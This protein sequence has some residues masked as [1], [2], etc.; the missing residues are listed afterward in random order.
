MVLSPLL[1][2]SLICLLALAFTSSTNAQTRIQIRGSDT[3]LHLNEQWAKRF[4]EQQKSL[5]IEVSGGGSG[6]GL[7]SLI[8]G[9]V[10]L[11]AASRELKPEEVA[12]LTTADQRP[13]IRVEVALDAVAVYV[14]ESNQV[15]W[16]SIDQLR[17]IY[18]GSI[19]NWSE[20]GGRNTAIH[21]HSRNNDS[22]TFAFFMDL[23]MQGKTMHPSTRML[24][25]TD[26]VTSAISRNLRGIGYGGIGY[27][28]G[29]RSVRIIDAESNEPVEPSN[30]NVVTE[31]Y[32]LS[33]PLLLYAR[34]DKLSAETEAFLRWILGVRGQKIVSE[35]HYFPLPKSRRVLHLPTT[36]KAQR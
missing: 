22:G 19:T 31:L 25:S 23:V 34:A 12:A 9:E 14:H 15:A 24:P 18:D 5:S 26:A 2:F 4:M 7:R 35:E 1:K 3:M 6:V 16:L 27:A 11:A 8:A 29:V 30:L 32:P 36:D 13:P 21:L 33:R 20:V 17:K 28:A 10:E